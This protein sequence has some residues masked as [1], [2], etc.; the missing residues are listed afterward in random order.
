MSTE[1]EQ[2][3]LDNQVLEVL[4]EQRGLTFSHLLT[5]LRKVTGPVLTAS[6]Q[7]LQAR[8]AVTRSEFDGLV[9]YY[10]TGY[11][12]EETKSV[13]GTLRR[14]EIERAEIVN[15]RPPITP[16]RLIASVMEREV[17]RPSPSF[18]APTRPGSADFLAVRSG[19]TA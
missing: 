2:Q 14:K 8:K 4:K 11:M 1:Q 15:A 6:L 3:K 10:R 16:P 18:M 19:G 5:Q 12:L 9:R 7:R 13:R 17:Y